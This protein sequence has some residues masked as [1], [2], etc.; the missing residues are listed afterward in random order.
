MKH[1]GDYPGSAA[2]VVTFV[3]AVLQSSCSDT[4]QPTQIMVIVDAQHGVRAQAA[5]LRVVVTGSAGRDG[6]EEREPYD[7]TFSVAAGTL[8][9]P[10]LTA[11]APIGNDPTR[12]YTF[13]AN[14]LDGEGGFVAEVR[15]ISGYV[16]HKNLGLP[17]V[18]Q[19]RCIQQRCGTTQTCDD[20]QCLDATIDPTTLLKSALGSEKH[21]RPRR[22]TPGSRAASRPR[23]GHRPVR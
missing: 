16:N 20:G 4:V 19:D 8:E 13:T 6:L 18:L 5:Q 21:A 1:P 3:A 11:L 12:V 9:W 10:H 2:A 17:L 15:A 14:A 22:L 7:R 23:C